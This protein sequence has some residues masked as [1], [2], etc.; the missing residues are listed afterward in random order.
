MKERKR[1]EKERTRIKEKTFSLASLGGHRGFHHHFFQ[2]IK[3]EGL[4]E[5]LTK[6]L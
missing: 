1:A 3:N 2:R 6:E 4:E 5:T